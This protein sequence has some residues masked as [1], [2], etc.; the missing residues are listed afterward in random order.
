MKCVTDKR[1]NLRNRPVF[2]VPDAHP[3]VPQ[4]FFVFLGEPKKKNH[5]QKRLQVCVTVMSSR[6]ETK[7]K[8][9]NKETAQR[10]R[11][12][13]LEKERGTGNWDRTRGK[14]VSPFSWL[15]DTPAAEDAHT[16]T[17]NK[18]HARPAT[19][20]QRRKRG[21]SDEMSFTSG[22][23]VEEPSTWPGAAV[24]DE[25]KKKK[26]KRNPDDCWLE[27]TRMEVAERRHLQQQPKGLRVFP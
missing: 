19:H 3:M 20:T 18:N 6:W 5:E 13:R 17:Q 15:K 14:K 26:K 2:F 22:R 10:E 9:K 4:C 24:A 12:A 11:G 27:D 23:S 25:Q 1:K 16:R 7:L 8:Y 21:G